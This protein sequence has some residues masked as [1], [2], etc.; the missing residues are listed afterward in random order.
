MQD[1]RLKPGDAQAATGLTPVGKWTKQIAVP[2]GWC[3]PHW[4]QN[5]VLDGVFRFARSLGCAPEEICAGV[6]L[7][8]E[9][10]L[11][12][13][14]LVP[15][16]MIIDVLEWCAEHGRE[17][18]FGLHLAARTDPRTLGLP[19][20]IAE[21]SHSV[22]GFYDLFRQNLPLHTTGYSF[23]FSTEASGGV[24][25]L[26]I[27]SEHALPARQWAE[28]AVSLQVRVFQRMIAWDWRPR[29]VELAH[30]RQGDL[31]V[32][33]SAYGAPVL[34]EA[35]RNA[36]LFS[37]EDLLWRA[38]RPHHQ[39]F[40]AV[41]RP[42][43]SV[44][45]DRGDDHIGR[46]SEVIRA[47]LP[48][49]PSLQT[50]ASELRMSTRSLQR[51]LKEKGADFTDVLTATRVELAQDYLQRPGIA[52]GAV[53]ARLGFAQVGALSRMLRRELGAS[54]RELMANRSGV[55]EPAPRRSRGG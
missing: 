7:D 53:A 37:A 16:G 29:G 25:R 51:R 35:G 33:E 18:S 15:H 40:N 19:I 2:R 6:G 13:D 46:V 17:P 28:C 47:S 5:N 41:D 34:F 24:G 39:P 23:Q 50:V 32:Y 12:L 8:L 36:L 38:H 43:Q 52:I 20:M 44:A 10:A 14:A 31:G 54:P 4:S 22:A 55:D 9:Q 48:T 11:A 3:V 45:L 49:V 30:P 21:R 26:L 42:L 27:H 1:R